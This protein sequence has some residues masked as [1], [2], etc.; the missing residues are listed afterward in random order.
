[1]TVLS[2]IETPVGPGGPRDR[3]HSLRVQRIVEETADARSIVF[4]LPSDLVDRFAYRPGQFVTL[5]VVTDHDP[6]LRSYSM[7]SAPSL[8]ADLQVTVKRVPGGRVSNWLNDVLLGRRRPRRERTDGH[9]RPH[10]L[11]GRHR[12]LRRA[13][14]ASP[15]SSRSSRPRCTPRIGASDCCSPTS[16]RSQAIF[17]DTLDDLGA[18]F[19]GR[20]VVQHHEDVTDGFVGAHEVGAFVGHQTDAEFLICGPTGFMDVVETALHAADVDPARI[21]VERFTPA[22]AERRTDPRRAAR[23]RPRAEQRHHHG[24]HPHRDDRAAREARPSCN[25]PAGPACPLPRRARQGT[26]QRAWHECSKERSRWPT[27]RC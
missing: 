7:S 8:D 9:V 10:R 27:T 23:R 18:R 6:Q 21:H 26:A 5:R 13:V 19:P 16:E 25:R 20:L 24:R 15:P 1:M 4:D 12:R 17:G 14:A 3:Y 22:S 11:A 2:C